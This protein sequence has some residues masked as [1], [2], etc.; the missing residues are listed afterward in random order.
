MILPKKWKLLTSVALGGS[1]VMDD[2]WSANVWFAALR[3]RD[4]WIDLS[5]E[6]TK[7][8]LNAVPE[9][10]LQLPD[11]VYPSNYQWRVNPVSPS[12]A[13]R[14]LVSAS[15]MKSL[16]IATQDLDA[17]RAQLAQQL[18]NPSAA[19]DDLGQMMSVLMNLEGPQQN[20]FGI[21]TAEL[22]QLR[23]YPA[24]GYIYPYLATQWPLKLDWYWCLATNGLS[25]RVE[26]GSSVEERYSQFFLPLL[27]SHRPPCAMAA[28]A[29][30]I[31]SV[32]KDPN[33]RSN[34]NRCMDNADR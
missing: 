22:H 28:R 11:V 26:S 17:Q 24:P 5:K 21:F 9:H 27:D 23:V 6:I 18:L 7:E 29:L 13:R 12:S 2:S 8:E 15:P 4:P 1:V 34:G 16:E 14:G 31:A 33:A 20:T 10:L 30:W 19:S 32:S 25:R 3:A